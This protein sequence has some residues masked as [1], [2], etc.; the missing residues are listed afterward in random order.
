MVTLGVADVQRAATFY[1]EGLGF[2]QL[3][4]PPTVAFFTLHG[5][6]LGLFSAPA[7]AKEAGVPYPDVRPP[8]NPSSISYNVASEQE[9]E[10]MLAVAV[11]AGATV[12]A[13]PTKMHWGG[14]SAYFQDLDGHLWE[15][16]YN[17][18]MWVG[19]ENQTEGDT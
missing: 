15:I 18:F 11:A 16:A 10:H 7:L 2:P 4:S 19:P 17:P 13:E 6:W 9:V 12:T 1:R 14:Y 8:S 5:T 3:E